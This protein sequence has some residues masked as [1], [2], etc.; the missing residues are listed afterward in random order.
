MGTM[1]V[2]GDRVISCTQG[3]TGFGQQLAALH[4]SEAVWRLA[5]AASR[6]RAVATRA[7]PDG[8]DQRRGAV[9]E[10]IAAFVHHSCA[11]FERGCVLIEQ[12]AQDLLTS[13]DFD[14]VIVALGRVVEKR[15]EQGTCF[16]GYAHQEPLQQSVWRAI[17]EMSMPVNVALMP[18]AGYYEFL[19]S[20]CV[21]LFE[22]K[23]RYTLEQLLGWLRQ[24]GAKFSEQE[25]QVV[26][27]FL[28]IGEAGERLRRSEGRFLGMTHAR[29][30]DVMIALI[31]QIREIENE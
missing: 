31:R 10:R 4:L 29:N 2:D 27:A 1:R 24:Y 30:R 17:G 23:R 11:R 19:N 26:L 3:L 9:Q 7:F 28:W 22:T 15:E 20:L 8:L 5:R 25:K 12:Y 18:G 6:I 21:L 13:Q 16:F 14:R